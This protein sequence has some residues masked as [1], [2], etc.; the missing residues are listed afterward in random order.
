MKLLTQ[1]PTFNQT[2]DIVDIC[3]PL[4]LLNVDYFC[5]A[6]VDNAGNFSAL[7]SNPAF[8]EH[9]LNKKYY[10]ADIHLAKTTQFDKYVLWDAIERTGQSAQMYMEGLEFGLDHVFTIIEKSSNGSHFYHFAS[11]TAD[12][13][14]NQ[15]YLSNIDLMKLFITHFKDKTRGSKSLAAAFDFTFSIDQH[16]PGFTTKEVNANNTAEM[17]KEFIELVSANKKFHVTEGKPL[18]KREIEILAWLHYGKSISQVA[19]ILGVSDITI[20]KHISNIKD[21]VGYYTQFQLGE[22][23]SKCFNHSQDILDKLIKL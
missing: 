3:R 17:R 23:F 15:M 10:N 20:A 19:N 7:S 11:S 1:H 13:S 18:S 2:Q 5:H 9:Y 4:Q 21:K 8:G 16:A 6:Y 12:S 22:F 14:I